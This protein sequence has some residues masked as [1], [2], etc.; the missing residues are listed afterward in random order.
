MNM[1]DDKAKAMASIVE[2]IADKRGVQLSNN[3]QKRDINLDAEGNMVLNQVN[4]D[5]SVTQVIASLSDNQM[6]LNVQKTDVNG[7][8]SINRSNGIMS[9]TET[10]NKQKDGT[11]NH[12][13]RFGFSDYIYSHNAHLS[14]LDNKGQWGNMIDREQ[15]MKGFTQQDYDE[16]IAQLQLNA[17]SRTMRSDDYRNSAEVQKLDSMLHQKGLNIEDIKKQT[18][19]KK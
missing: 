13:I 9:R 1:S 10:Y 11:Y 5:N 6:L 2:V 7:N 8:M 18:K 4:S 15:A 14:P 17:L 12:D 19:N 16:H 3:F